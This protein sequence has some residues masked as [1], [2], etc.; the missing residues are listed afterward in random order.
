MLH[1][2]II[3]AYSNNMFNILIQKFNFHYLR[4]APKCF[5]PPAGN[6]TVHGDDKNGVADWL[7]S[8]PA[9]E[10]KRPGS[11]P[12]DSV[13]MPELHCQ[14]ALATTPQRTISLKINRPL[15]G[16]VI[17]SVLNKRIQFWYV[18]FPQNLNLCCGVCQLSVRSCATGLIEKTVC[19]RVRVAHVF[20][21]ST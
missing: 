1:W 10:R 6:T 2:K 15:K 4:Q 8:C 3:K 20:N 12:T 21:S 19:C 7:C 5:R 17:Y 13:E 18:W 11:R 9:K 16:D 14:K